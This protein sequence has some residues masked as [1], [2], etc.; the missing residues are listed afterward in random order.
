MFPG[1]L[2]RLVRWRVVAHTRDGRSLSGVAVGVHRDCIV[3]DHAAYL[4]EDGRREDLTGH[5]VI[6]RDN[7][8]FLQMEERP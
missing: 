4:M 2:A 1:R 6:P 5:T 7:L 8:S 3:L